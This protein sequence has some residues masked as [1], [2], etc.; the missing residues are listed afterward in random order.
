M[1]ITKAEIK[2]LRMLAQKKV[3]DREKKFVVEGWKPLADA[4]G[5]DFQIE[6][7]AVSSH[8]SANIEC[9]PLL[10]AVDARGITRRELS[11]V[12]LKQVTDTVH[13][14]GVVAMVRQEARTLDEVLK[15]RPK[16]VVLADRLTDP[17]NLGT[18]IRTCDW[19][20]VDVLVLSQGCV[21]LYNEKVVRSTSGSI[22]HLPVIENVDLKTVMEQLRSLGFRCSATSGDASTSYA[23]LP[24]A[25]KRAIIFGNEA[26]GIRQDLMKMADEA[27]G[28][29]RVGKAE[30][31][32]VG[33]ACGIMLAHFTQRR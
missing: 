14:Q 4:L 23:Q 27:M 31:L 6:L 29:P 1:R 15:L 19:F 9:R 11:E 12:E 18:I 32:N 5:S 16:L 20:G 13:A 22:F 30:S 10:E 17:G 21:D 33:V 2:L 25:E 26:E 7:V 8:H 24:H 3:R 28:I